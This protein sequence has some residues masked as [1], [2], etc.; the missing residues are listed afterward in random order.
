MLFVQILERQRGNIEVPVSRLWQFATVHFVDINL[1]KLLQLL[2]L[3]SL[4]CWS[5]IVIISTIIIMAIII[6]F[7]LQGSSC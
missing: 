3:L 5:C 1:K 4:L 2:L 7:L 6:F